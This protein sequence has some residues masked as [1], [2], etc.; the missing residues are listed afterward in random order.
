[1]IE[2]TS[3]FWHLSGE[4][5]TVPEDAFL[6]KFHSVPQYNVVGVGQKHFILCFLAFRHL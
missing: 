1:M 3:N 6:Q 2:K 4:D 5:F